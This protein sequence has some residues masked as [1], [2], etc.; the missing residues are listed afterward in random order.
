MEG[1]PNVKIDLDIAMRDLALQMKRELGLSAMGSP[2]N[3]R[4]PMV[5]PG[6]AHLNGQFLP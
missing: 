4:A 1:D 3:L 5:Q 2:A 6:P